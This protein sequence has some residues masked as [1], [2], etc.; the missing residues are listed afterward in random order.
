MPG[1]GRAV[2][3][4]LGALLRASPMAYAAV[5]FAG[6]GYLLWLGARLLFAP[7]R[8]LDADG[9]APTGPGAF[10]RGFLTNLLNPKMGVFYITFLPQFVPAGGNVA[11]WTFVLAAV[12]VL[13]ALVWFAVLIAATVPLGRFLRRPG[14]IN[15]MD[16]LTGTVFVGFGLRLATSTAR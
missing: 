9:A 11:V 6:A 7:R 15:A 16:R 2:S 1:L 13:L 5:K 3:L 12:H 4:G 8:A 10:R 14:A